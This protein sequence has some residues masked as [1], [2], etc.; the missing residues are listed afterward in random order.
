M[1]SCFATDCTNSFIIGVVFTFLD[2]AVFNLFLSALTV[3]NTLSLAF[4]ITSLLNTLESFILTYRGFSLAALSCVSSIVT[5][6]ATNCRVLGSAG[7][8]STVIWPNP[9]VFSITPCNLLPI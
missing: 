4:T 3:C 5:S 7:A 8:A 1:S 6:S 2:T 9:G